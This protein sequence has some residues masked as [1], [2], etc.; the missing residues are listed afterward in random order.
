MQAE[1]QAAAVFSQ[2]PSAVI[3]AWH[4]LVA[5]VMQVSSQVPLVEH[6]H[7]SMHETS[8]AHVPVTAACCEGQ[9]VAPQAAQA[10]LSGPVAGGLEQVNPA[11]AL[12][13]ELLLHAARATPTTTASGKSRVR[14]VSRIEGRPEDR[15]E[16]RS[17]AGAYMEDRSRRHGAPGPAGHPEPCGPD[18]AR[19]T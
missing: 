13:L 4:W 7:A 2:S 17:M 5:D 15:E 6:G 14:A 18:A 3:S 19:G 1:V 8:A 11:P 9:L 16:G 10:A 12:A